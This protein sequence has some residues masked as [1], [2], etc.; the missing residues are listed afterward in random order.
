M[1]PNPMSTQTPT[2]TSTTTSTSSAL[3][4]Q[5]LGRRPKRADAR[6]NYESLL[7]AA[8]DVFAANGSGAALE[9]IARSAGVGI[10][11]L[12]R[13]FPTRQDLL[14]AVYF[15][16]VDQLCDA[17]DGLGD[18]PPWDGLVAWL[19]RFVEYTATKR[20]IVEELAKGS[21]MFK[22]CRDEI[23]ASGTPLLQRAQAAGEVRSDITFD[24]LLRLLG[25]IT[26]HPFSEPGQL[27]RVLGVA[28]DG[29]RA[30]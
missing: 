26:L 1:E 17:A 10:G 6:R 14:E 7:V 13:H 29:I 24:D 27:D 12:Y 5:V 4:A 21:P 25:G 11:T 2:A 18:L 20:A 28:I 9:E 19:H 15:Y 3:R 8:R 22:G 30:R 16:E 23:V